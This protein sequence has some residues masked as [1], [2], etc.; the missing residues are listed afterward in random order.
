VRDLYDGWMTGDVDRALRCVDPGIVWEAIS[1][2]PD[3][4]TYRGHPGVRRY[5][6]DWLEDFDFDRMELGEVVG[7]SDR[8]VVSQTGRGT[9]KAS[10]VDTVIEYAVAYWFGDG[11]INAIKEFRTMEEALE[12]ADL[13]R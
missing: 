3:A 1:D 2:A 13:A 10:G 6:E 7:E 8:L 9:G 5:M 11:K 12:A 4:G